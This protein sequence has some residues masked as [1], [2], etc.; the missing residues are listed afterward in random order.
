MQDPVVDDL[1]K[2]A[3]AKHEATSKSHRRDREGPVEVEDLVMAV[4]AKH[5]TASKSHSWWIAGI[6]GV[7]AL[8]I[9]LYILVQPQSA[10]GILRQLIALVLLVVSIGEIIDGFRFRIFPSAPWAIL[11]G[12]IGATVAALTL[13]SL[14]SQHI[15]NDG[16][17]QI[18][19]IGL[20]VYGILGIVAITS[21]ASESGID[22]GVILISVLVIVLGII[23]W[24]PG[25]FNPGRARLLGLASVV[26]GAA[27]LFQ[28][29][30]LW[31]SGHTSA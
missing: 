28:S 25:E 5:E 22:L 7:I 12:G 20:L 21:T 26:G 6:E 31:K 4:E 16:S 13:F 14:F 8:I 2:A 1:V 23:L 29:Y 15:S 18:L 19:S 3:E 24:N 10:A 17:R 27:L 11:R 9:G 30:R